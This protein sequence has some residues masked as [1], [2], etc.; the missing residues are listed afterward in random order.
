MSTVLAENVIALAAAL[1]IGGLGL[2]LSGRPV[3]AL[4]VVA[5][6]GPPIA[7]RLLGD[8]TRLAPQ[9]TRSATVNYGAAF[10]AYA[11]SAVAVQAAVSGWSHPLA[12]A[13]AATIAWAAGL[14]A[15]FAPGGIGVRELVYV[16]LLSDTLPSA[17]RAAGAVTM[18]LVMVLAELGVLLLVGLRPP[19]PSEPVPR[20]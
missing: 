13:G 11:A 2:A 12:V 20:A 5:L 1:A 9:R 14:V 4:A 3:W 10:A 19:M 7:V 8:R 18:R 16:W 15:I 17:D 6:A